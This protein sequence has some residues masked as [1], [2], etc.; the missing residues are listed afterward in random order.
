MQLWE[1]LDFKGRQVYTADPAES[2]L[3][4]ARKLVAHN[5]GALAILDENGKLIGI[6]TERDI[7]RLSSGNPCDFG[8]TLVGENM[9]TD[10]VTA[11]PAASVEDCLAVMSQR[12]I[13][14]LPVMQDGKL[15]GMISQGDLVKASLDHARYE[16][17]QLTN[18]VQGK[19][20]A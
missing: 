9:S 8:S 15:V 16:A 13:R 7:L 3:E 5:V 19:Y 1:I 14:H 4:A 6:F 17:L 18:F 10:L 20:P 2:I 12:R 11:D